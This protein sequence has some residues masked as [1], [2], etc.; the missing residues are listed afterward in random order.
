MAA[1]YAVGHISG[2]HFNPAVTLAFAAIRK[3]SW[4][5]VRTFA[6]VTLVVCKMIAKPKFVEEKQNC[7]NHIYG[8]FLQVPMYVLA[9]ILGA[10]LASLTL[11]VLFHNQLT[12]NIEAIVT[13]YS[14]PTSDLQAIVW[15]FIITFILMFCICGVATDVR[16]VQYL[17]RIP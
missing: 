9:Q 15:E 8:F 3:F 1:I 11:K 14:D 16:A 12:V 5:H 13:Q 4:K 7:L 2:A 10:T 17:H 6:S